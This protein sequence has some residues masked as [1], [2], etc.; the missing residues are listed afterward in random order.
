MWLSG[1]WDER[2]RVV[3][4]KTIKLG[5][6]SGDRVLTELIDQAAQR[7]TANGS[8]LVIVTLAPDAPGTQLAADPS[9]NRRLAELNR[10]LRQYATGHHIPVTDLRSIVCPRTTAGK[11]CPRM[12]HGILLRPDGYHFDPGASRFVAEQVLPHVLNP[13]ASAISTTTRSVKK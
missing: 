1:S 12:V 10:L 9:R 3:G 4:G 13:V 2:D 8:R 11:P 6:K 5:S 7:L